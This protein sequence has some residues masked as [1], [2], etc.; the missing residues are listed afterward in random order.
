VDNRRAALEREDVPSQCDGN[1]RQPQAH[2][3][4]D[5]SDV[6]RP[7]LNGGE[8]NRSAR[9]RPAIRIQFGEPP[10][11]FEFTGQYQERVSLPRMSRGAAQF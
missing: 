4:P 5:R 8:L 6:H 3:D 11:A 2:G 10:F 7:L 9:S 1:H